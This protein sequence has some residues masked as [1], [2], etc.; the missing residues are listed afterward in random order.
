MKSPLLAAHEA[1]GARMGEVA[2]VSVP[3]DFGDP[4]SEYRAVREAG[5][6]ADRSDLAVLAMSGRD[7]VKM[8]QGL[9]TNDV[10]GAPPG[11]GVYAGVLTPKGRMIADVRA[12]TRLTADGTEVLLLVARE[13]LEGLTAHLRKYV[14]P[15]FA[16][17]KD[18]SDEL[19]VIGVYGPEAAALISR[20]VGEPL[21]EMPVEGFAE[22]AF[23]TEPLV[24]ARTDQ[25]GDPGYD[26]VVGAS[27]APALWEALLAQGGDAGVAPVGYGT[28]HTLRVEAG[29]PRYGTDITEETIPTEAFEST[30]LLERTISFTKGCYTGQEVVIRIAHRGHVNRHLRGLLLGDAPVPAPRTPLFHTET[31]KEIGWTTSA[32]VSPAMEQTI[33]LGYVR[34]EVAPGGTVRVGEAGAASVVDLPFGKG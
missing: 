13:A 5:G 30:G 6:V 19:A 10:A 4:A 15:M 7:P 9:L 12:F 33:A 14:P 17:W 20:V 24:V 32:A 1:L 22:P 25:S 27:A 26:L 16:R 21:P 28:L 31:R 18:A 8:L 34:R 2:G 3:R 11:H 29:K 23:G